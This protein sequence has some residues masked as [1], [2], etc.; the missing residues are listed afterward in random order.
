MA[1][2]QTEIDESGSIAGYSYLFGRF[3]LK[4]EENSRMSLF[5]DVVQIRFGHSHSTEGVENICLHSQFRL[6][7][8]FVVAKPQPLSCD[9]DLIR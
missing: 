3:H 1:S 8:W 5:S 6:R 7:F 2:N 9:S 4:V